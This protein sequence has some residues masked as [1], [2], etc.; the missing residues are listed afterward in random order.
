MVV[1]ES[2]SFKRS[3][4]KVIINKHKIEEAKKLEFLKDVFLNNNSLHDIMI[5]NYKN[6]YNIEKKKGNLKEYYSARLNSK[7]RLLMKPF[8]NYPYNEIE[9]VEIEFVDIDNS[10][11]GKG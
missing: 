8:G 9:I 6:I 2:S 1:H 11:Y 3:Y 4:K 7:M 5:S 10:H